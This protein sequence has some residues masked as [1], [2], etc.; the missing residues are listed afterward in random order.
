M[1][2]S[3]ILPGPWLLRRKGW[4]CSPHN[5]W[6]AGMFSKTEDALRLP[7]DVPHAKGRTC[8]DRPTNVLR[9]EE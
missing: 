1:N 3:P 7:V 2:T 5:A 9:S 4:F 6:T 8:K